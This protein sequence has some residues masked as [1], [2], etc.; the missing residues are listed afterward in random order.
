MSERSIYVLAVIFP[1]WLTDFLL[2]RTSY[3]H[4]CNENFVSQQRF[5]SVDRS[6][7]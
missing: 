7:T 3:P 1:S 6:S 2:H 4:A 5:F